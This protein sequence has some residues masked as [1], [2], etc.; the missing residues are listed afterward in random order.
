MSFILSFLD[1]EWFLGWL[2]KKVVRSVGH[3]KRVSLGL[4]SQLTLQD[5]DGEMLQESN[6]VLELVHG[7][8]EQV[9]NWS[10]AAVVAAEVRRR[11]WSIWRRGGRWRGRSVPL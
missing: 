1:H 8:V 7:A 6:G 5:C 10:N 11:C 3:S 2:L 4:S 9:R